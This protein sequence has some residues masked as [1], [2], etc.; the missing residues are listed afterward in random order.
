NAAL[1]S[2]NVEAYIRALDQN[3]YKEEIIAEIRRR[4]KE[5]LDKE[6]EGHEDQLGIIEDLE[7]KIK[8]YGQEMKK[9]HSITEI[10]RLQHEL[11]RVQIQL[12]KIIKGPSIAPEPITIPIEFAEPDLSLQEFTD[13][14]LAI[15]PKVVI[16][17]EL[18]IPA[19][20]EDTG[21]TA[22]LEAMSE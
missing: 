13:R 11:E 5:A 6:N 20:T 22:Q 18:D 8:E 16:P 2:E 19:D 10:R 17:V 21:F 14:I 3:I 1:A 9:A 15:Q 7:K 4:Q 12:D